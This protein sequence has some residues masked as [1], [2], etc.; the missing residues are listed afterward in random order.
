MTI[1]FLAIGLAIYVVL[2]IL[3]ISGWFRWSKDKRTPGLV[4]KFSMVGFSL[5][6]ASALLGL[7]T[8]LY[9]LLIRSFPFY[10]PT[11]MRIYAC[12]SLL[13]LLGIIFAIGGLW[14]RGP[15][16]WYALASAAGTLLFWLVVMSSE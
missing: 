2:P 9:A 11:L 8:A 13:S 12:G 15:L 6:S 1:L 5:A 4:L 14:R 7:S 16:R 3:L 10:D